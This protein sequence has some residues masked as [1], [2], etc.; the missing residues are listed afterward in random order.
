[1]TQDISIAIRSNDVDRFC[2]LVGGGNVLYASEAKKL[3]CEQGRLEMAKKLRK[4]GHRFQGYHLHNAVINGHFE[5][6][7]YLI[8]E[9]RC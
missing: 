3:V 5:L 6:C 8:R 1:M 9:C 7:L 2:K 4:L